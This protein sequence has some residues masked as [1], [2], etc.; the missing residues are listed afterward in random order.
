MFQKA[1]EAG[2]DLGAVGVEVAT[3]GAASAMQRLQIPSSTSID[4]KFLLL[5]RSPTCCSMASIS[6]AKQ[7]ML[8][9]ACRKAVVSTTCAHLVGFSGITPW[10]KRMQY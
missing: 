1:L 7:D 2:W 6:E 3:T 4:F 8:S 9:F 10:T 5:R